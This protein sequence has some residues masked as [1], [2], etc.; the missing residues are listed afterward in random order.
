MLESINVDEES[1][2]FY[3]NYSI[4]EIWK[5]AFRNLSSEKTTVQKITLAGRNGNKYHDAVVDTFL[6]DY[7]GSREIRIPNGYCFPGQPTLMQLYVAYK[8]K[9][10]PYFGNF[11]GTGAGKTLSAIIASRLIDSKMTIIV[12]PND[13]VDQWRRSILES[14]RNCEVITGMDAFNIRYSKEK[15]QYLV[16]NYDKFSQEDSPNLILTL[17]KQK[18][19]FVILDEVHFTK[20]R[21][22]EEISKRRK[23]LDG[24]M[25]LAKKEK[26]NCQVPWSV[27]HSCCK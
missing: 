6:N 27:C 8:V 19:E 13:V 17:A 26:S 1:V 4:D 5:I 11:S 7:I 20:I 23:N 22:E 9:S 18:I 15:H 16:L 12:C 2:Q 3:L 10:L 24:L 14:F 21:D 25:T